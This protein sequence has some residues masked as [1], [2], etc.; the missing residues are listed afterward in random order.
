MSSRKGCRHLIE[1]LFQTPLGHLHHRTDLPVVFG[2]GYFRLILRQFFERDV[3]T[4]FLRHFGRWT[5]LGRVHR[6][7][8]LVGEAQDVNESLHRHYLFIGPRVIH[9]LA[10]QELLWRT[11]TNKRCP[12]LAE[13]HLGDRAS[14]PIWPPPALYMLGIAPGVPHLLDWCV[15]NSGNDKITFLGFNAHIGLPW[16]WITD[17][18]DR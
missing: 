14:K 17:S 8:V 11:H 1:A 13:I 3:I 5:L 16:F 18:V 6:V 10:T 7:A 4:H 9:I 2:H 15:K 12:A